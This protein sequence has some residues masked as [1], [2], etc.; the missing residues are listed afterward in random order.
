MTKFG[1]KIG[2]VEVI[3]IANLGSKMANLKSI[4][5]QVGVKNGLIGVY[6]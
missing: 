3:Y 6:K 5:D 1:T 2:Q 4:N